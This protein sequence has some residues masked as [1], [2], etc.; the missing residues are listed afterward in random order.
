MPL[1][2]Q[3]EC[4]CEHYYTNLISF[5]DKTNSLIDEGKAMNVSLDFNKAF[6]TVS[7]S[8]LVEKLAA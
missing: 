2:P 5:Y 6:H 3:Y 1:Y 7:H 4:Q 8:I